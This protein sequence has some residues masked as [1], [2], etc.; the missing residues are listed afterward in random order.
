[1]PKLVDIIHF[2]CTQDPIYKPEYE[3]S[4][5]EFRELTLQRLKKFCD[6]GFFSVKD[7]TRGES[8]AIIK[9][10][11]RLLPQFLLCSFQDLTT[12]IIALKLLI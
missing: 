3:C 7:Y 1:M 5:M 8:E 10:G 12:A 4:L 11:T 9:E 2:Y 6:Q